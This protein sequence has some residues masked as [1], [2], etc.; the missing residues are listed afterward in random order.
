M[1]TFHPLN[2]LNHFFHVYLKYFFFTDPKK[3]LLEK[4]VCIFLFEV[5]KKVCYVELVLHYLTGD[6][7]QCSQLF[8]VPSGSDGAFSRPYVYITL[9]S[10]PVQ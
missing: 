6:T 4:S 5:H 8:L 3:P 7:L 10:F 2:F 9:S 1:I